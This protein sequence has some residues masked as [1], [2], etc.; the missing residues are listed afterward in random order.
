LVL[1]FGYWLGIWFSDACFTSFDITNWERKNKEILK[2]ST[3]KNGNNH[4]K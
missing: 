3:N 1:V 2:N 4:G